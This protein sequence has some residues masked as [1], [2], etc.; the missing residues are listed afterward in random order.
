MTIKW[1]LHALKRM[2]ERKIKSDEVIACIMSGKIIEQ[3]PSDRPLPSCLISGKSASRYIHTVT[4]SDTK[5]IYIITTYEPNQFEWENGF[6]ER[7]E[8]K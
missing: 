8:L 7:K 3:Y 2:R 4:S 6:E 5:E 1:T